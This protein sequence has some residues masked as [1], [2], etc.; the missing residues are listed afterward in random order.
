MQTCCH[1]T[2]LDQAGAA[3]AVPALATC[4]GPNIAAIS[5]SL[6]ASGSGQVI[7]GT[8]SSHR[9]F[10]RRPLVT[11]CQPVLGIITLVNGHDEL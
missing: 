6:N 8:A 9:S 2:R 5:A 11:G 1:M 3:M 10:T 4:G 7:T